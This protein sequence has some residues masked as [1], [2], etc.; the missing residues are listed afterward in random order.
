MDKAKIAKLEEHQIIQVLDSLEIELPRCIVDVGG[1]LEAEISTPYVA[2]GWRSLIIDP[3]SRCVEALRRKFSNDSN[4]TVVQ[5]ACS[6]EPGELK[7]YIGLDG[8]GSEVSTLNP[9]SDPWMDQVRSDQFEIVT[10][11]T[12]TSILED[13]DFP[14]E[15]GILKIDTESWDYNV[16]L[17]LDFAKFKPRVIVTEEY[18]WDIQS[19]ISKHI[20]LEDNNYVNVGFVG[21]NSIWIHRDCGARYSMSVMR[22][23]L[24]AINRYPSKVQGRP[25]LLRL[26]P[27]LQTSDSF[28]SPSKLENVLVQAEPLGVMVRGQSET[29]SVAVTNWL[30]EP[31]S[32]LG[33][34]GTP[35]LA[36]YH[37]L[38][39]SG[40]V[41]VWDGVRTPLDRDV[42]VGAV[43]KLDIKV[44]APVVPGRYILIIDLLDEKV[45]WFGAR[46]ATV[47]RQ[48]VLVID[49][50]D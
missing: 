28:S 34:N 30:D 43:A 10:V 13:N 44:T 1:N 35:I 19:T 23:W 36:S 16:L 22:D 42:N 38:R 26:M 41:V 46:G 40:E 4:S 31:I 17:G 2:K 9:N 5:C 50:V 21:Y 7:L 8:P 15:I 32:H 37:W 45:A 18:Y 24:V 14:S 6:N 25:D 48:E 33:K 20:Y 12:L 27:Y 39:M 47:A 3:Q 49:A 29:L 11:K